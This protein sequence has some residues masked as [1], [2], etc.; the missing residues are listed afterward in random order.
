MTR[1][2]FNNYTISQPA[3]KRKYIP[4]TDRPGY[5]ESLVEVLPSSVATVTRYPIR[6][7]LIDRHTKK[8]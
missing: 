5:D 1:G 8:S 6:T 3:D 7:D 2:R 4:S